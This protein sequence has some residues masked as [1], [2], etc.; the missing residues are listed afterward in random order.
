MLTIIFW[1]L[2]T[3]FLIYACIV[4]VMSAIVLLIRFVKTRNNFQKLCQRVRY[5][6][7]V[8]VYRPSKEENQEKA[9][10]TPQLVNSSLLVPGDLIEI[11]HGKILPCDVILL[12]GTKIA[13]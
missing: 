8:R 1:I 13:Y 6:T 12:S 2:F 5:E 3:G 4:A 9:I 11:A 7:E 10:Q